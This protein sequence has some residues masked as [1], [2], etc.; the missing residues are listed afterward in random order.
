MGSLTRPCAPALDLR[1]VAAKQINALA[2]AWLAGCALVARVAGCALV[3][4]I[5]QAGQETPASYTLGYGRR[6]WLQYC[7]AVLDDTRT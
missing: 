4:F 3:A 6:R 5:S 2:D 7:S 1:R